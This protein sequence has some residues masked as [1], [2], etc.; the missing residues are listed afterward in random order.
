VDKNS[1]NK[2]INMQNTITQTMT[3]SSTQTAEALGSG[4]LAV[5]ST[6]ALVAFMENTA[7]QLIP[8]T[9]ETSSVGTEISVKHLKASAVGENIKCT[10]TLIENEGK[11]YV[12]DII[13]IDSKNQIIGEAKHTRYLIDIERFMSKLV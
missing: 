11:K 1:K 2:K 5:F 10:A 13:A 6:P 7:M 4:L 8:T 9:A 12:F 3:V